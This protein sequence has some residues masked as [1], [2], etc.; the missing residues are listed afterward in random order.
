MALTPAID[1]AHAGMMVSPDGALRSGGPILMLLVLG[2]RVETGVLSELLEP[3]ADGTAEVAELPGAEEHQEDH[4]N[5]D[6]LDR[7]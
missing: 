5:E 2:G 6:Q 7:A 1:H 3:S 4:D